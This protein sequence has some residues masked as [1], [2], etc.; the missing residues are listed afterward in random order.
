M[1]NA[2]KIEEKSVTYAQRQ[3]NKPLDYKRKSSGNYSILKVK[4]TMAYYENDI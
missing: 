2:R 1:E 3:N 4:L